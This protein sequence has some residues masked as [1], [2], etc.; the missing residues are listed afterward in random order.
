MDTK[1]LMQITLLVTF[2]SLTFIAGCNLFKSL[3]EQKGQDD[4]ISISGRVEGDEYNAGARISG[5]VDR[6]LV[7]EGD[8]VMKGELLGY[9]YSEQLKAQ[10]GSAK[11]EVRI[12][13]NKILQAE[14]QLI[15]SKADTEARVKQ[16]TANLNVNHSQLNKAES[17]YRQSIAQ[18]D[19]SRIDVTQ[20]KLDY[21]QA[22]AN[23]NKAKATLDYNAKE[24]ERH[25]NLFKEDAIAKTR[26]DA[27]ETQYIAARE[28]LKLAQKQVE[29]ARAGIESSR[30]N[31]NIAHANVDM[32]SAGIKEGNSAIDAG[33]ATVNLARVGIYDID[34]KQKE[35]NNANRMLE[36]ARKALDS[37]KA[38]LEDS[39]VYAPINGIVVS[40]VVEPGEVV[41]G[42][43]PLV[44]IIDMDA[45]F[46]RVFLPTAKTGKLK[47]GNPVKIRPDA[48]PSEEFQGYVYQISSKSE[49]TP[50]NVET[51]D[52]RAKLV[53]SVKIRI[54]DN[55]DRK[56]KPGMPSEAT[57]DTT[58]TIATGGAEE[59]Q[60]SQK[61]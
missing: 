36:K 42:G 23:L 29:K 20:A 31:M 46:L 10:L 13:Q 12:W 53:F 60:G 33:Q 30:R 58:R 14:A 6:I 22:Q 17:A 7:K 43:T 52:Q 49:F 1:K 54:K 40:K 57:I 44:T 61:K 48:L 3:G 50:K 34:L 55:K 8:E 59:P 11:E 37:A 15:Q 2:I 41:A 28:D 5:K 9:I 32:G 27:V 39:R 25:K 4:I 45:L 16:A 19:R 51:K 26:F 35:V 18:L 21:D 56:L 24:F 38:D 47:I